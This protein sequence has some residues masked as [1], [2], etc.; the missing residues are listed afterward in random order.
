MSVPNF[1]DWRAAQ[2]SFE[3]LA[4]YSAGGFDLAGD[5]NPERIRGVRATANLFGV[6][7]SAPAFGRTFTPDEDQPGHNPVVVLSDGFWRRRFGADRAIVGK[8][9]SLDNTMYTVIGVMPPSFDYP[10]GAIRNDVWLPLLWSE[11]QTKQRGNHW[12]SV[13]GRLKPGVDSAAATAQMTTIAKRIGHDFPDEQGDRG[14]QVDSLNGVIV[15]RVR[16]PLLMLL[17]AVGLVLL[18]YHHNR[19]GRL[20]GRGPRMSWRGP[21]VCYA[22]LTYVA[23]QANSAFDTSSRPSC[24]RVAWPAVNPS[25]HESSV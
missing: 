7:G 14:I 8:P 23:A 18:I 6:L 20:A 21:R 9:I 11:R 10:I 17:G 16:T 24:I 12:M 25:M 3:G 4:A 13:I 15:G 22:R 19:P 1:V 2:R 5:G